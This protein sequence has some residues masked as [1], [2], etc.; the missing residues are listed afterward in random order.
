MIILSSREIQQYGGMLAALTGL[1]GEFVGNLIEISSG[2]DRIKHLSQRH[3]VHADPHIDEYFAELLMRSC[4]SNA[5][6]VEFVEESL[7]SKDND[8][9]A[10]LLWPESIVFGIGANTRFKCEPFLMFDE[11]KGAKGRSTPSCSQSVADYLKEQFGLLVGN[12]LGEILKEIN[13]VDEFGRA[14]PQH[15]GNVIKT[16]HRIRFYIPDNGDEKRTSRKHL[17]PEWKRALVN[18][19]IVGVANC[20]ENKIE[21]VENAEEK[22]KSLFRSLNYYR[23]RTML[24]SNKHFEEAMNTIS[25]NYGN[26]KDV[27]KKAYLKDSNSREIVGSDGKR[28]EQIFVL[29]RVCFGMEN[30]WGKEIADMIMMHLWEVIFQQQL[31]YLT[32]MEVLE[33]QNGKTGDINETTSIGVVK[34]RVIDVKIEENNRSYKQPMWIL[35]I[36]PKNDIIEANKAALSIINDNN[37]QCGIILLE[38][39]VL[40]IKTIFKAKNTPSDIWGKITGILLEVEPDCWY[41]P[42]NDSGEQAPFIC[43]G[44]KAHQYMPRSGVDVDVIVKIVKENC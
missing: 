29:S 30:T 35:G 1:S 5:E 3:I 32:L 4:Y 39:D 36:S 37:N 33:Q 34:R 40:G 11:H 44:S 21:L 17:S 43:N 14:H 31:S 20:L 12:S 18:A 25:S 7:Y 24:K 15:L 38:D 16:L 10:C 41:Q 42:S 9:S 26:Q 13:A 8:L 22:R 19:C 23:K 2:I 28:S 6:N 27:F